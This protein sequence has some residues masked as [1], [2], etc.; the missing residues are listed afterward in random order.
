MRHRQLLK[1]PPFLWLFCQFHESAF[2][3]VRC[4][5]GSREPADTDRQ[6]Q[7][8][9][10]HHHDVRPIPD[11]ARPCLQT[12][13]QLVDRHIA[14]SKRLQQRADVRDFFQQR[15]R[16]HFIEIKSQRFGLREKNLD[17]FSSVESSV[18]AIR[19]RRACRRFPGADCLH[20]EPLRHPCLGV[21]KNSWARRNFP[22][23]Y[24]TKTFLATPISRYVTPLVPELRVF[25]DY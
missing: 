5:S 24:L 21:M 25:A 6:H 14:L 8:T 18:V 23:S 22:A 4:F 12:S 3:S 7:E 20:C 13:E 10:P 9:Q 1:E 19:L 17:E 11:T 16:K 2:R 15:R